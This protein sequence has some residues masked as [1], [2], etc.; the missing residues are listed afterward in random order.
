MKIDLEKGSRYQQELSYF[1]RKK[2]QKIVT[3]GPSV[4]GVDP[5]CSIDNLPP[6]LNHEELKRAQSV[7]RKHKFSLKFCPITGVIIFELPVMIVPLLY[8]K[9]SESV[10]SL[11]Y[12]YLDTALEMR[13]WL[14]GDLLDKEGNAYKSLEKVRRKHENVLMRMKKIPIKGEILKQHPNYVWINMY[15]MALNTWTFIGVLFL[16]PEACGFHASSER[17]K[18]EVLGAV[19]YVWRTIA[20]LLGISEDFS[21][22]CQDYK[23]TQQICKLILEDVIIPTVTSSGRRSNPGNHMGKDVLKITSP[24]LPGCAPAHILINYWYEVFGVPKEYWEDMRWTDK[25]FSLILK[26]SVKGFAR[27]IWM[28]NIMDYVSDLQINCVNKRRRKIHTRFEKTDPG[29]K[30]TIEDYQSKCPYLLMSETQ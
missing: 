16:Y 26:I 28:K 20:Y 15:T 23:E 24:M 13:S 21:L 3:N 17:E 14:E 27:I 8:T 29:I 12:R 18:D 19:N 7:V 6:W 2:W 30:Y 25:V 10:S 22:C 1:I 11:F 5:S 4:Q 9:K